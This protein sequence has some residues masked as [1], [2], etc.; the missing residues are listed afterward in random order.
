MVSP[1]S[2][3]SSALACASLR[4]R[5]EHRQCNAVG[6]RLVAPRL[7]RADPLICVCPS[8]SLFLFFCVVSGFILPFFLLL[9]YSPSLGP[10]YSMTRHTN[11][12]GHQKKK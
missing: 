2:T 4:L 9:A 10:N 6:R 3:L 11:S 1:M 7:G 8:L 5:S 12:N